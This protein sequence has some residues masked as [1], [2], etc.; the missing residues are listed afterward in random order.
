MIEISDKQKQ[1]IRKLDH[2]LYTVEFLEEWL[3][4]SDSVFVNAP[5]ALQAMGADG[6]FAAV[7]MIENW[8]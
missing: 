8:R 3:N 1:I 4:R 2:K 7:K 6:F 5:A